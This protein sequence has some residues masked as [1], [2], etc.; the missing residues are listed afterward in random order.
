MTIQPILPTNRLMLRP[1]SLTDAP[2]V[3]LLAGDRLVS[4]MTVNIPYPY[5]DGLA[6]QWISTHAASYQ[7]GEALIYA[8]TLAHNDELIGTVSLTQRTSADANLGY[9]IGVP[10][11]GQGYCTEAAAALIEFG[12]KQCG[13]P[14]IYARHLQANPASGRVM[15]KNGFRHIRTLSLDIHGAT[16]VLEHYER[17]A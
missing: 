9:W 17:S 12:F 14:L 5:A 3:Q 1:F 2:R 8:I 7:S 6:E 10:Y 15:L 16:Q 13:I 4:V 11:W